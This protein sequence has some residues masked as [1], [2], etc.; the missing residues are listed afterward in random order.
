MTDVE[1]LAPLPAAGADTLRDLAAAQVVSL[2]ELS[3]AGVILLFVA[4]FLRP[5]V[6]AHVNGLQVLGAELP[7]PAA[8]ATPM[9]LLERWAELAFSASAL[10][11]TFMIGRYRD[12]GPRVGVCLL[13]FVPPPDMTVLTAYQRR[14]RLSL[15]AT[16]AWCT[17]ASMAGTAL[18]DPI[19]RALVGVAAFCGPVTY[20]ADALHEGELLLPVFRVGAAPVASMVGMRPITYDLNTVGYWLL[21][22]ADHQRLLRHAL[23]DRVAAGEALLEGWAERIR[24]P[25]QELLDLVRVQLPDMLA[26]DLLGL[27]FSPIYVP[28][29]TTYLPRMPAQ[30][31]ATTPHCVRSAMELLDEPARRRAHAWLTRALD[32]LVCI[33]EHPPEHV[34]CELLRPPPLVLGQEALAPWA[35]GRVWDLTFER[36]PCAVPL[37]VTLPIETHLNL[38]FLRKRLASY[39]DQNLLSNLLEGIRFEADVE[40]QAVLVPHLISLPKGFASVRNELYRLQTLGWYRFFDHLPFWPIYLNGQGATARKLETRYR[41]TTECGGPR[42]P[43]LDGS[44][45][46]ALSINEAASVRHTCLRGTSTGTT[47]RGSST[48]RSASLPTRSSGAC[49]LGGRRR[50]SPRCR[51]SCATCRSC[52]PPPATSRSPS[53]SS[54]TTRKTISIS[55]RSRRRTGGNSEWC[56]STPTR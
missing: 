17:L 44:G 34:G 38:P 54:A 43:T 49:P 4:N 20:T 35:R 53:T 6:F 45:L 21:Q 47:R 40:L 51:W 13:P 37:D 26:E 28:P 23:E 41:R 10:A 9:R 18:A 8:R 3:A 39:P 52:S 36:A 11:T 46:R 32:Q 14:R 1:P 25:P 2:A 22:D 50:S 16:F 33:E 12:N 15:G 29:V 31:P 27:P 30:L 24:P 5:L 56:S 42:R 7:L 48:C 55:S 19:A